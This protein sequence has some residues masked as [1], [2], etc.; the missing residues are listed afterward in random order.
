MV[1]LP[2]RITELR[3]QR[4]LTR[5]ALSAALGLPRNAIEKFESGR[6]TPTKEQ[7]AKLA[8][9]FEVSLLYLQ[10]ESDDPTRQDSWMTAALSEAEPD[11]AP[12]PRPRPAAKPVAQSA[13]AGQNQGAL[14]SSFL[15]NKAFQDTVRAMVLE[16]LRTPEGQALLA[17]IV[18]K[19]LVKELDK[20]L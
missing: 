16:T 7:Q 2:Q 10:G 4:G 1:T 15:N 8:A 3:T 17:Q 14:V 12:K 19:E 9:F 11:P 18:R 13:G 5:P 6:Q 20:S